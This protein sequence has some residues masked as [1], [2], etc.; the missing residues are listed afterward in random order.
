MA[1]KRWPDA[2]LNVYEL[3]QVLRALKPYAVYLGDPPEKWYRSML[4]RQIRL[5]LG[6]ASREDYE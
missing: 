1:A 3:A 5:A 6:L 4:L 2:E